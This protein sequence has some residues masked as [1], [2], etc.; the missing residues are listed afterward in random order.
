MF[1]DLLTCNISLRDMISVD[2]VTN[3]IIDVVLGPKFDNFIISTR[4]VITISIL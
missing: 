2:D 1:L 4:E 3:Y